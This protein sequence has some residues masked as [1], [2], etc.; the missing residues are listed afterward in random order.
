MALFH[1]RMDVDI[2][3]DLDPEVRAETVAREKAYSQELQ[4][5][6]KWR[7]IWRIV[8]KYSNISIFDVD[9]ADELHE[10]LWNLPLFPYMNIEI[11]PLTKHGSDIKD[12]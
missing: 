10:I 9:S 6:G 8:G 12:Q 3:R 4:R 1:V 11:M 2:P 5:E 7:E